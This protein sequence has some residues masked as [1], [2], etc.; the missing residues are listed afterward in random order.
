N[1]SPQSVS[2]IEQS[3]NLFRRSIAIK[4]IIIEPQTIGKIH[5]RTEEFAEMRKGMKKNIDKECE[6]IMNRLSMVTFEINSM[7]PN[8]SW[9]FMK[10]KTVVPSSVVLQDLD[11]AT[12]C[13]VD[14]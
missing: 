9:A 13:H 10:A 3:P 1:N 12:V 11:D 4:P 5:D 6:K 2:P 14:K 7:P 8:N